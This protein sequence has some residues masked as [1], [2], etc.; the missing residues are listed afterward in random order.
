MDLGR[1][2]LIEDLLEDV[3]PLL[4]DLVTQNITKT[5]VL[6]HV[7]LGDRQVTMRPGF[8]L[9][10]GTQLAN[11]KFPPELGT[12]L[13]LID[14]TITPKGLEDQLL[15]R[16][17]NIERQK[18]ERTRIELMASVAAGRRQVKELEETLLQR[19]VSCEGSL[20]DDLDLIVVLQHTK[21]TAQT[22]AKQLSQAADAEAEIEQ[23][24]EEFR[25][26]AARGS[27]IFFLLSNMTAVNKM[28]QNGLPQFISLFDGSLLYSE[29]SVITQKRIQKILRYMTSSMWSFYMRSLYKKDRIIFTLMLAIRISL[30]AGAIKPEEL[31]VFVR[32]GSAYSLD[33]CPPKPAR[34]ISDMTWTNLRALSTLPTF[35]KIMEHVTQHERQWR[36]WYDREAPEDS[37]FPNPY[38]TETKPFLRLLVL[39]CWCLDRVLP[40]AKRFIVRT[41]GPEYIEDVLLN[42]E[43]LYA[44]STSW[45]P[46]LNLLS[47]GADPSPL[48]EQLAKKKH[49]ELHAV[50]MGQGQ[51]V[52]ARQAVNHAMN[53]G[54][55]VL[56]QN[57]HLSMN[58]MKELY[59]LVMTNAPKSGMLSSRYMQE[60]AVDSSLSVAPFTD[61][62][63]K[64]VSI[65]IESE[66]TS[67]ASS[68][69]VQANNF[70]LW[71]T[72][73]ENDKFPVNL[74]QG[75]IKYTNQEPEGIKA[76]LLRAYSDVTQ[77][78]LDAC[79]S[80]E[81]KT[82]LYT[83]AFMHCTLQE[84]RKYGALGWS[85]PYD[86]THSDFTASLQ[87]IQNHVDSVEFSKKN[88]KF[89]GVD[90]KCVRYMIG[91][92]QYGGRITDDL[93]RRLLNTFTARFFHEQMFGTDFD[94]AP[95]YTV[96]LLNTV[97]QYEAHI[98]CLP[99][100]DSPE[101]FHL[102][103]N[104]D[105]D[106]SNRTG[107]Y[108]V[109]CFRV[110]TP[111]GHTENVLEESVSEDTSSVEKTVQNKEAV[112]TQVCNEML[113]K[114]PTPIKAGQLSDRLEVMGLL[115][116]MH[117]FLRQEIERMNYLL[118]M[119]S[120]NIRSLNMALQGIIAMSQQLRETMDVIYEAKVPPSWIKVSWETSTLGFWFSELLDRF[121]QVYTWLWESRPLSF[122]ITG[123]FNPQSFLT[124]L[125]QE[126]ARQNPNWALESVVL[127]NRVTRMSLEEIRERP[128]D[129]VYV[130]G[131]YLQ[132]A[133]WD[134]RIARIIEPR[135]KQLFD[136]LPV[137]NF[138]AQM[139]IAPGQYIGGFS[140]PE[141]PPGK[142]TF[143]APPKPKKMARMSI[144]IPNKIKLPLLM[145]KPREG[146]T[147][148]SYGRMNDAENG[149]IRRK[150]TALPPLTKVIPRTSSYELNEGSS[151]RI[152]IAPIYKK[153]TRTSVNYITMVQLPCSR[154]AE[155][156]ILRSVAVIGDLR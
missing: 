18:V 23:A 55:W 81:W 17:I 125:R 19:L 124:A 135:P 6:R 101:A 40:Q 107:A 59:S 153:M 118:R 150:M 116:P 141:T 62:S 56:L 7:K 15:A 83:L 89:S 30:F 78:L 91:E 131:L 28:Y 100:R 45:T 99:T 48:I 32:G 47:T 46:M 53:E 5:D 33:D 37:A 72:A 75:S 128:V 113:S 138:S 127:C 93:D 10:M 112:V 88:T 110:M 49:I 4:D 51:D 129:G 96:P 70:R 76:S 126:V 108:I 25:P 94:L 73:A 142:F 26:V 39:R 16:V 134:Y 67:T 74:L 3:P 119:L 65:T 111:K 148:S 92:I 149:P 151:T 68:P 31:E 155:H 87:F 34:W 69:S 36:H 145:E 41:L 139:E 102:H 152:Y 8:K 57:C 90:W 97:A 105:I 120:S 43:I 154:S 132:G 52:Q 147:L 109:D 133:C 11:P 20:V 144:T 122:W 104:A 42:F 106:Y 35:S 13:C 63:S 103:P 121:N 71:M 21:D 146:D 24:R 143:R 114:L 66:S 117:I 58:Y 44:Q 50:A 38:E 14:F 12:R 1:P 27:L 2:L 136:P 137:I 140:T 60:G 82:M 9:F 84:R 98:Q 54:S 22:V 79:I 115:Q 61:Y 77:D 95:G 123:F 156:W 86:F 80:S 29:K 85:V 64:S 130:H